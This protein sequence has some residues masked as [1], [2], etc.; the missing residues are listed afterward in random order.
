MLQLERGNN[1]SDEPKIAYLHPIG[2]EIKANKE[3]YYCTCGYSEK[4][5]F[6]DGSHKGTSFKPLAF[7]SN[8]TSNEALCACKQTKIAPYCDGRHNKL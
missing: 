2:C 7:T 4:Q 6:C 3:Y 5:P 8:V 1:M